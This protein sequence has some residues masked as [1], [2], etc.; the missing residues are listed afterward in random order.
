MNR[1]TEKGERERLKV[2][3]R[4]EEELRGELERTGCSDRFVGNDVVEG[5]WTILLNP[6]KTMG[7]I[8]VKE[9]GAGKG[10]K[11]TKGG[12]RSEQLEVELPSPSLSH[13]EGQRTSS[14]EQQVWMLEE[15]EEPWQPRVLLP[16]AGRGGEG[17]GRDG[18]LD[19][20]R[21]KGRSKRR[22][23]H[24]LNLGINHFDV[25]HVER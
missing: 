23:S 4:K 2:S 15:E 7:M 17:R 24:L 6:V 8:R 9:K 25:V 21:S 11:L 16:G 20:R 13:F 22:S 12:S 19:A 5:D 10:E 3:S 1:S 14:Q 18:E